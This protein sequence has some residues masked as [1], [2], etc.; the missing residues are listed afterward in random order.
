MLDMSMQNRKFAKTCVEKK[1]R[2]RINKCLDDLKNLMSNAGD[3]TRFQKLE[4]AEILEMAVGF[5]KNTCRQRQQTPSENDCYLMA[6]KQCLTDFQ[7][8]LAEATNIDNE[9]KM[10]IL[11]QLNQR[12]TTIVKQRYV[13]HANNDTKRQQQQR[14]DEFASDHSRTS[15]PQTDESSFSSPSACS[16]PVSLTNSFN[17]NDSKM[18]RP[19]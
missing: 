12:F 3:K 8:Y 18:W 9:S 13:A 11:H 17:L 14:F 10:N 6:Y 1:R 16:S 19:W 4:K 15:T 5:M 2:D 7:H